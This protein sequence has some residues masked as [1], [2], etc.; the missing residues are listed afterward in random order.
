MVRCEFKTTQCLSNGE[1]GERGD[2]TCPSNN[3]RCGFFGVLCGFVLVILGFFKRLL[4]MC[5]KNQA[6]MQLVVELP[7]NKNTKDKCKAL[8][9]RFSDRC[10]TNQAKL[11]SFELKPSEPS[12]T[13]VTINRRSQLSLT[14]AVA[15]VVTNCRPRPMHGTF[16]DRTRRRRRSAASPITV[17]ASTSNAQ[18]TASTR[19]GRIVCWS[20][21]RC[22][23]T[24][25][26]IN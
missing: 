14:T 20:K 18:K 5:K 11:E 8:L 12:S 23:S 22:R 24:R 10:G 26:I 25:L 19:C 16:V 4:E 9:E 17:V 15:I 21:N 13:L 7:V 2:K 6:T 3:D 1:T